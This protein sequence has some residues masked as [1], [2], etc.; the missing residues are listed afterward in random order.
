[1]CDF[2]YV[3]FNQAHRIG[4]TNEAELQLRHAKHQGVFVCQN[5]IRNEPSFGLLREFDIVLQVNCQAVTS[6]V[7]L[8]SV[9]DS[10]VGRDVTFKVMRDGVHKSVTVPVVNL[11]AVACPRNFL[12]IDD[13]IINSI[14]L[15]HA[16]SFGLPLGACVVSNAGTL[17]GMACLPSKS[18]LKS[19]DNVTTPSFEAAMNI[20]K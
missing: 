7:Q 9:F 11:H 8:E 1:M 4:L 10:R 15:H 13:T 20:I 19:I 12:E 16:R 5:I 18:I 6:Y 14:S 3:T 17:M 2:E